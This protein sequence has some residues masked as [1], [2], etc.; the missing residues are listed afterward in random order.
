MLHPV[1]P[2][3][4]G[5]P[6]FEKELPQLNQILAYVIETECIYLLTLSAILCTSVKVAC[7]LACRNTGLGC[8]IARGEYPIGESPC[9]NSIIITT[10]FPPS[11]RR[12][13]GSI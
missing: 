7:A 8:H 11:L 2:L 12:C 3:G 1:E 9:L 5:P 4:A 13:S 10:E 6:P